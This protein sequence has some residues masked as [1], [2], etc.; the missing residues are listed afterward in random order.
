MSDWSWTKGTLPCSKGGLGLRSSHLHAPAAYLDTS[1][2]SAPLVE[3]LVG[4]SPPTSVCADETVAF[5]ALSAAR[6]DWQSLNN[7]DVPPCQP[8][9][10][11]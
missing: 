4:H 10:C 7:I 8:L 5:I 3:D 1:V 9:G 11:H 2:G 6:P